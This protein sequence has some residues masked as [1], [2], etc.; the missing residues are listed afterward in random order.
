MLKASDAMD[1]TTINELNQLTPTLMRP[2]FNCALMLD[3]IAALQPVGR[4]ALAARLH[5]SER[6]VRTLADELR[7]SGYLRIDAAGME[8]TEA[9]RE[10]LKTAQ[11]LV[12]SL[13]ALSSLETKLT[14][15]LGVR[16]VIVCAGNSDE[17]DSVL[18]EM[19][20]AAASKLRPMLCDGATLAVTGGTTIAAVARNIP[21][22][23]PIDLQVLPA[24][25]GLGRTVE[26]QAGTLAAE[27]ARRLGGHH[28]L[29]HLPDTLTPAAQR[30]IVKLP[31][32]REVMDMLS[33]TDVLMYGIG[34]ADDMAR[35]R[36]MQPE[37]LKLLKSRG[38]VAEAFGYYFDS[39]GQSVLAATSVGLDIAHVEQVRQVI[40][41]AGGARKADAILAVTRHHRHDL[42][43]TDEGAAR[44]ILHNIQLASQHRSVL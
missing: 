12:R 43:V 30:E 14:H 40:A 23:P 5:M 27:I 6:E 29:M 20:R 32:I 39:D 9:A 25:G 19:G 28:R 36:R 21:S 35:H 15:L 2:I 4:R 17:D 38:A 24:R 22:G 1:E 26:T 44:Q 33:H 7:A 13:R 41:V 37:E 18:N 16:R 8:L 42:L 10:P 34:R 31:E 3:R 11:A